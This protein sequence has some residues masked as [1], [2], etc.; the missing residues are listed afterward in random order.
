MVLFI[1][2]SLYS[3]TISE[4]A[5]YKH[6]SFQHSVEKIIG[7]QQICVVAIDP[8][9]GQILALVNPDMSYRK[10]FPPG[11]IIKL[12]TTYAGLE[13]GIA[14]PG[15]TI[16]CRNL[17]VVDS[18]RLICSKSCGHGIVNLQDAISKSCNVYFYKLGQQIGE[19]KLLKC[20]HDFGLGK[21]TGISISGENPGSVPERL[22]SRIEIARTAIG[23]SNTL[24][25][26]AIQM[27][28]ITAAIANGGTVYTPKTGNAGKPVILHKIDSRLGTFAFLRKAMRLAVTEGTAKKADIPGLS[29]CG[30]TGSPA[31]ED[32]PSYRHGWFI[33]FAPYEK[34]EIAL[35]VFTEWGHGGTDAAPVARRVLSAWNRSRDSKTHSSS[36]SSSI[37][38][39]LDGE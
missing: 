12:L 30:K 4:T 5:S 10:A 28:V 17:L 13:N 14:T 36:S 37:S 26:T 24:R 31:V 21:R 22:S 2:T 3:S 33:G 18:K 1:I 35:A 23:E 29:V 27:A 20:F 34:P 6:T 7:K 39:R 15:K 16:E 38:S 19:Q 8:R 25:V 32:N 11:S 9:N